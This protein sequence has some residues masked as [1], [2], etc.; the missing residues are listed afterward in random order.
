MQDCLHAFTEVE[1]LD[2]DEG[3][4]CPACKKVGAARKQLSIY[5]QPQVLILH[6]KRFSSSSSGS[7][8]WS[9]RLASFSKVAPPSSHHHIPINLIVLTLK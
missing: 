5:R 7:G 8:L 3:Y 9:G 4:R 1:D 2:E 6:L